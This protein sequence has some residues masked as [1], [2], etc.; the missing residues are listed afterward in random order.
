MAREIFYKEESYKIVGAC[1]EVYKDKGTGFLE[2]VY[3][4]CLML[5]FKKRRIVFQEKPK[6]ELYYKGIKLEKTYEPDFICYDAIILELKAVKK[7]SPEHRAQVINYLKATR[8]R[9]GLLINF[10]H[11]PQL[12]HERLV[13]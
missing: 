8:C 2:G 4:E 11:Y 7:L 9:L 10:G 3:Q 6:L 1:F 13:N 5:E 12:E